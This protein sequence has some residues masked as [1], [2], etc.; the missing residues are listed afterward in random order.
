MTAP[1]ESARQ[2]LWAL[3]L[4]LPLGVWYSF[5]R[6]LG[7]RGSA[8]R[9]TLFLL[10]AFWAWLWHGFAVCDGDLRLGTAMGL[11]LG[12]VLWELGPGKPLRPIFFRFWHILGRIWGFLLFPLRKIFQIAKK[13]VASGRK[14]V[15]IKWTEHRK[16]KHRKDGARRA[17]AEKIPG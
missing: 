16:H 17:G 14:W 3:A 9:D 4:G 7:R 13:Y 8:L 1:A 12:T 5:L 15:K 11:P 10:G 6:P 2:F